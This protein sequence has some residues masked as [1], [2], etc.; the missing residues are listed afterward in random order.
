M[1]KKLRFLILALGTLAAA[2]VSAEAGGSLLI[3]N[4]TLLTVTRGVLVKADILVV[5]GLIRKIGPSLDA[6]PGLPVV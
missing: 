5:D 6:P 3:K 1:P 4:G 2:S